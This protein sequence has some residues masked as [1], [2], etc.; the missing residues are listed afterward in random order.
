MGTL[1]WRRHTVTMLLS[2]SIV[3]FLFAGVGKAALAG[4]V[5]INDLA[6][7]LDV[8]KVR[9]EA[10]KLPNPI[11][12]YTTRTFTGGNDAFKRLV[13]NLIAGDN[14]MSL[15]ID[16][17]NRYFYIAGGKNV[18]VTGEQWN[19]AYEA[20]KNNIHGNDYTGATVAAISSIRN[21]LNGRRDA[22]AIGQTHGKSDTFV[23]ELSHHLPRLT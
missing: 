9:I 16:A 5:T 6:N 22:A 2:L 15:G 18:K 1:A 12:I 14:A 20:F 4:I 11:V 19:S 10:E 13:I 3:L 7:V 17:K 23:S 21:A 8:N